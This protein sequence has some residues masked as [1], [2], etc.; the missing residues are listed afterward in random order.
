MPIET[1]K[2][3]EGLIDNINGLAAF[4]KDAPAQPLL[5][6]SHTMLL[7]LHRRA[8]FAQADL[9]YRNGRGLIQEAAQLE[10]LSS[11]RAEKLDHILGELPEHLP[12]H[13]DFDAHHN[14]LEKIRLAVWILFDGAKFP[15]T[16]SESYKALLTKL[17]DW[18]VEGYRLKI[19]AT[20]AAPESQKNIV[21]DAAFLEKY[22]RAHR[23]G[24]EDASVI[25]CQPI[26]G[27]FSKLTVLFDVKTKSGIERLVYRGTQKIQ[28]I[29]KVLVDIA[30]EFHTALYAFSKGAAVA[31]PLWLQSDIAVTGTRF[32]VSRR[33]PGTNLGTAMQAFEQISPAATRSLA[34]SLAKIHGLP[35]DSGNEILKK[36]HIR[37]PAPDMSLPDV[38]RWRINHW[39]S[40]FRSLNVDSHPVMEVAIQWMLDN[41]SPAE[42]DPVLVHGDYG[43]HN[44]LIHEDKVSAAL[45]WE[46]THVGDR[47]LD[48]SHILAGTVGMMDHDLFMQTY[49][50]AG[51]KPV[52]QFRLKYFQVVAT[53]GFMLSTIDGQ[54]IFQNHGGGTNYCTLGLGFIHHTASTIMRGILDAS[55]ARAV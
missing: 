25:D 45:D 38:V 11:E 2:L 44:I 36:S 54:N 17:S 48:L 33:A 40:H 46:N 13:S 15:F 52:S 4:A 27:G 14:Y 29:D 31:E 1:L 9:H 12:L 30:D 50:E 24:Y 5:K 23:P 7:E 51:G 43:L 53:M 39:A 6:S 21:I 19:P 47:A 49:I 3:I 37:P 16:E 34:T 28:I 41:V 26:P 32:F 20:Q 42:D 35:L 22:L 10:T 55:A 18:E 8:D